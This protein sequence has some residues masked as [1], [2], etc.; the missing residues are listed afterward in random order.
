MRWL[1]HIVIL[2]LGL[3]IV[4]AGVAPAQARSVCPM[5]A[6]IQIDM[7]GIEDCQGCAKTASHEQKRNSCDDTNCKIKCSAISNG[8]SVNL[9][10]IKDVFFVVREQAEQFYPNK[11][12]DI[13]A[14]L[15]SQERPPRILA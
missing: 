4:V 12:A 11:V 6:T 2:M 13:S 8:I 1:K 15:N 10:I 14:H 7:Q 5:M 3:S 9:P